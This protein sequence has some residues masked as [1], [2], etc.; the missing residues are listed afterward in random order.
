MFFPFLNYE[1]VA[2]T[3][4][5]SGEKV[6]YTAPYKCLIVPQVETADFDDNNIVIRTTINQA[7]GGSFE[8][9]VLL[10]VDD[11]GTS[12]N[13]VKYYP[14][15]YNSGQVFTLFSSSTTTGVTFHVFR[16]PE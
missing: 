7:G 6:V 3:K 10:E 1:R 12:N 16:L 11:S 4:S 5:S 15:V 13:G 2:I 9:H 14:A 8:T